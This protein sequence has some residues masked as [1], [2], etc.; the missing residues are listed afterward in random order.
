MWITFAFLSAALLGLYD[1]CKKH[2]LAD[3]AVIP[4]LTANTLLCSAFFLP[5]I[6]GGA[7]GT[8]DLRAHSLV[9]LK[10]MI[11]LGSW[12]CGYFAMARL[13]LSTVGPINATRPVLTLTAAMFVYGERPGFWQWAGIVSAMTGLLL[14]SRSSRSEGIHFTHDRGILLL[15]AAT[16]LGTASGLFDK[17]LMSAG[18]A[19]L[20]RLFVQGYYN[21]YQALLMSF[22]C[23][24][25]HGRGKNGRKPFRWR[26]SIVLV[27]L[28]LTLADL[29]YFYALSLDGAMIGIVSMARRSSVVVSFVCAAVLFKEKNLR[30]KA[31]DL[32]LVL[33]SIVCLALGS[34]TNSTTSE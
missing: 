31:F 18:G 16:L 25:L 20:D 15:A 6:F 33:L 34:R 22:A 28:F 24:L 19:C 12:V 1:V 17:Y 26:R 14:L 5:F 2:A 32:A 23:L 13:P 4:V 3:N 8:G 27:S 11:V 10:S 7:I 30:A 29:C 9:L 21:F